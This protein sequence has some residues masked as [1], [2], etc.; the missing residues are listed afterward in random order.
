MNNVDFSNIKEAF[1]Q[2]IDYNNESFN[3]EDFLNDNIWVRMDNS[4]FQIRFGNKLIENPLNKKSNINFKKMTELDIYKIPYEK[5][6]NVPAILSEIT[7]CFQDISGTSYTFRIHLKAQDAFNKHSFGWDF[8]NSHKDLILGS[9]Y[10]VLEIYSESESALY[11]SQSDK[12]IMVHLFTFYPD[13]D[14]S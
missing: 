1:L 13:T 3:N 12:N 9:Q 14:W 8:Q 6:E 2:R 5:K 7:R 4:D 10:M 11:I